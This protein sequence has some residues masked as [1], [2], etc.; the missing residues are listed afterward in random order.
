MISIGIIIG[1]IVTAIGGRNYISNAIDRGSFSI[2]PGFISRIWDNSGRGGWGI[3]NYNDLM[4]NGSKISG[5]TY[6]AVVKGEKID[7]LNISAAIGDFLIETWSGDDFKIEVQGVGYFKY[8]INDSSLTIEGFD[9]RGINAVNFNSI[10]NIMI[11]TVPESFRF[12]DIRIEVGVGELNIDGLQAKKLKSD[13]GV[14]SISMRNMQVDYLDISNSVGESIFSGHVEKDV[15]VDC[16]VG[17]VS[18]TLNDNKENYNYKIDCSI[19][20]ITVGKNYYSGLSSTRTINND[21]DKNM[22]LNCAI[23]NIIVRFQ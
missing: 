21:A 9:M 19:G 10:R 13:C 16:G 12:D 1:V 3:N 18:L 20:N 6:T 11:L 4:V 8:K 22:N 17:S 5:N 7:D 14:G 2:M 23:G 15:K